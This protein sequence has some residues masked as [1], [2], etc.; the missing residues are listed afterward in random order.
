MKRLILMMTVLLGFT[1]AAFA[2]MAE[3]TTNKVA[4]DKAIV[5]LFNK[6]AAKKNS[7]ISAYMT[8]LK[9]DQE[10]E[11]FF[12]YDTIDTADIVRL[13]SGAGG[14]TFEINYLI[15][16]RAGF[17]SNTFQVGYLKAQTLGKVNE[18]QP[19]IIRITEPAKVSIE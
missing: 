5:K 7:P 11:G 19:T 10:N 4:D 16:I 14:G 17:K 18:D 15:I 8:A 2:H 12:I 13:E 3:T 1:H 6:E 9:A